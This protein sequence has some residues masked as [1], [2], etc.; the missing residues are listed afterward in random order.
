MTLPDW[1]RVA[2]PEAPPPRRLRDWLQEHGLKTLALAIVGAI[3]VPFGMMI[4]DVATAPPGTPGQLREVNAFVGTEAARYREGIAGI[5]PPEP[6]ATDTFTADE[7]RAALESV[8]RALAAA[9]LDPAMVSDRD[10]SAFL[11][12]LAPASRSR[13]RPDFTARSA[14]YYVTQAHDRIPLAQFEPRVDGEMTYREIR[15]DGAH[16]LEITTAYTWV[17][18]FDVST[19]T[20][21][22]S[23]VTVTDELVWH[24]VPE[25][26]AD[27]G[28]RGLHLHDGTAAAEN[29]ACEPFRD[30]RISP[31]T[32]SAVEVCR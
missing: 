26:A 2:S 16:R 21:G 1:M 30:G 28:S 11:T 13:L 15:V 8:R 25:T 4:W 14:P 31:A 3:F 12:L 7:V 19:V 24:V 20:A 27:V 32:G 29:V 5:D 10:P 9:R 18:P 22:R 17:Y 6:R 23:L